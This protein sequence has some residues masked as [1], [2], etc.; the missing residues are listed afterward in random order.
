MTTTDGRQRMLERHEI[1]VKIIE[2]NARRLHL[3][4]EI[5]GLD[6]ERRVAERDLRAAPNDR[7]ARALLAE[8]E[9]KITGSRNERLK[10][11][12]ECEW[13]DHTLAEFDG[14]PA[15]NQQPRGRA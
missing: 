13:L 14:T 1:V 12:A 15:S 4:N 11:D 10:L 7:A 3:E 2:A 8:I 9:T 6:I 5:N